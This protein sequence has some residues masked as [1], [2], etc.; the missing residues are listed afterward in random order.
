MEFMQNIHKMQLKDKIYIKNI[1]KQENI[2]IKLNKKM[3]K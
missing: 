2:S 3:N 1:I